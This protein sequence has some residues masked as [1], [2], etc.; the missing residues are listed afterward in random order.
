MRNNITSTN[1]SLRSPSF[2]CMFIAITDLNS[3][4]SHM[5]AKKGPDLLLIEDIKEK[6]IYTEHLI[7][8]LN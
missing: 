4:I 8:Q 3:Y 6:K 5:L 1:A 7:F 2:A